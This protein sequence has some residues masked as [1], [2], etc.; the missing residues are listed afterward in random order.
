[1][2]K[3]MMSQH[4]TLVRLERERSLRAAL[5]RPSVPRRPRRRLRS[6][7]VRVPWRRPA[8]LLAPHQYLELEFIVDDRR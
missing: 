7:R 2:E 1:L 6:L 4:Y 8:P 3:R 5:G